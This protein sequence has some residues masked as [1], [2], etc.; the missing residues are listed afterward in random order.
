MKKYLFRVLLCIWI[1]SGMGLAQFQNPISIKTGGVLPARAG[2]VV[3]ITFV[4]KMDSGWHIYAVHDVPDGP[5]ATNISI[6]GEII[7]KIGKITE[8]DP[9]VKFDE[10]FGM[11]TPYHENEVNFSIPILLHTGLLPGEH[12]LSATILYQVC[13]STLCYPPKKET[14]SIQIMVEEGSPRGGKTDLILAS[15][16]NANVNIDL[17]AAIQKGILSFILLSLSMGFLAL[18]TPCV[19]PMIPIT[20]SYFIHQGELEGRNPIK[21]ASVYAMGIIAT[22]SILGFLLAVFLG[23]SGANQLA[24]NPWVNLFIGS[25]FIYFALSLFGMYEI[26]LPEKLRQMTVKQESRG[27]YIGTLFMALT[28]TL[29]SFTCTV[30]FLGLLLVAASQG[31]WFWPVLGMVGFSTAFATPFFFLALFPQYLAKM[32]QSGG[33]LNSVKVV[34]GFMEIAA[35]LKFLSNTDLVWNW[36]FFTHTVVLATWTVIALITGIYLLGKIQLPH[37]SKV[38]SIGVGRLLMSLFFLTIGL[39]LS[40]GLVGRSIHGLIYSYLPPKMEKDS[41]VIIG[42]KFEEENFYWYSNLDE[43]LKEAVGTEKSVFIDFT[44][45]TCTNCR[46]MEANI[47]TEKEVILRFNKMVLV[48]LFT[49]GGENYRE[50]QQYE[51]DRFGT[52]AL[53]FYVLLN[54]QN[55]VIAT[56]PGLTRDLEE[57]LNFLDKGIVG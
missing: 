20:V 54:P 31:Q 13:N 41:G 47:F 30:Q 38:E 37:D 27:G 10:G 40:T 57:F 48:H 50:K 45:Y 39:Y 18:L 32:P 2:E 56:F 7:E 11:I 1:F 15:V 4:A 21:Q 49:D 33:W 5:T 26:Q 29:T 42:D 24:A 14:F 53:P 44:G 17:D 9:I 8:P 36:G 28:F 25:L 55:E 35:A 22:F 23:A 52:A 46:W 16:R 51:I 3:N 19:F 6:S 34:M 12:S 43:G